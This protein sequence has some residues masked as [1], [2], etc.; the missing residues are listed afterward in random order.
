MRG[1]PKYVGTMQDYQNLLEGKETRGQAL[2]DLHDLMD[3]SP[4]TVTRAL[5]LRD[6]KDPGSDWIYEEI[7]NPAPLWI[8]KGFRSKQDVIDLIREYEED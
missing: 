3:N 6:V 4:E 1:Y 7:E 8:F 2:K 5:K